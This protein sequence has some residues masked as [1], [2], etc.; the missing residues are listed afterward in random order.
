MLTILGKLVWLFKVHYKLHWRARGN[1]LKSC[2][3]NFARGI[4]KKN[5]M[6]LF[7]RDKKINTFLQRG[8]AFVINYSMNNEWIIFTIQQTLLPSAEDACIF[9]GQC[10]ENSVVFYHM[11]LRTGFT[12][13]PS[14][15]E[16]FIFKNE[17]MRRLTYFVTL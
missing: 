17:M 4:V 9:N 6:R 13:W 12:F 1:G 2:F 16:P 15:K 8:S 11:S 14:V 10:H 5:C 3:F 7:L